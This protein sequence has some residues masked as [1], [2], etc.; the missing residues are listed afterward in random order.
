MGDHEVQGKHDED[1]SV[2][3]YGYSDTLPSQQQ[4]QTHYPQ[5]RRQRYMR[6][7]SKTASML[8]AAQ[9]ILEATIAT[10]NGTAGVE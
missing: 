1:S 6:R 8:M 3:L 9:R 10:S 4:H 7:G 2:M 5:Q